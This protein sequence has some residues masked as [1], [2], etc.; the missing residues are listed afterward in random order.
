MTLP[1]Y[2]N[3]ASAERSPRSAGLSF[4]G[5]LADPLV[6][7]LMKADRVDPA[8]LER[9]LSKIAATLPAAPR[10]LP[11]TCAPQACF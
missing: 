6:R 7:L 1:L 11:G 10:T 8:V 9:D 3:C 4:P 5:I 2:V